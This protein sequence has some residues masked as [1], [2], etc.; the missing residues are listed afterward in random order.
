MLQLR[1]LRHD[2]LFLLVVL[3]RQRGDRVGRVGNRGVERRGFCA[4]GGEGLALS[5][6]PAAQFLDLALRLE[7]APRLLVEP[8][9]T[10]CGPRNT[11]PSGVTTG[12]AVRP[13]L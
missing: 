2:R 3:G 9:D 6:N 5:L 1:F 12:S 10:R 11:S 8:P 4:E 7:N 13:L